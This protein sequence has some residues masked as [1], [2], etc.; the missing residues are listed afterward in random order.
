MGRSVIYEQSLNAPC[1]AQSVTCNTLNV[2]GN[3]HDA[4]RS[5]TAATAGASACKLCRCERGGESSTRSSQPCARAAQLPA[6]EALFRS[7]LTFVRFQST[8]SPRDGFPLAAA[9][10]RARIMRFNATNQHV[11]RLEDFELC[12]RLLLKWLPVYSNCYS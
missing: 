10:A 5:H 3:I 11:T 4:H 7:R 6:R 1:R 9:A 12:C 8:N 2:S